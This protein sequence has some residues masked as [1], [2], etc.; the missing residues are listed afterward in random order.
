MEYPGLTPVPNTTRPLARATR[1][2]SVASSCCDAHG[3]ESSSHVDTTWYP[4]ASR[5]RNDG[6][7]RSREDPAQCTATAPGRAG[8]SS[9]TSAATRTSGPGASPPGPASVSAPS[10]S[11]SGRPARSGSMSTAPTLR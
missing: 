10:M 3:Y 2:S 6:A 9:P 4:A 8:P 1:S 5:A 11:R 7:T